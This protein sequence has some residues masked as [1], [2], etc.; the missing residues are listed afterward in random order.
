MINLAQAHTA[1]AHFSELE[2]R[3]DG[4]AAELREVVERS[5]ALR[6]ESERLKA[7][8]QGVRRTRWK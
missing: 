7:E 8:G 2:A 6:W 1:L 4:L 5:A 3:R